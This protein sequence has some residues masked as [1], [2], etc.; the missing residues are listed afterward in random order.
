M[1]KVIIKRGGLV[2]RNET[3]EGKSIEVQLSEKMAGEEIELGGKALL[4]TERKDG[5]LP[6]TNI[7]SDRWDLAMM[8]LDSVERARISK[9]DSMGSKKIDE[10]TKVIEPLP[11]TENN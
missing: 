11:G 3:Y 10:G 8:A 5:V 4:Y 6:E 1:R 9:R 2:K 7:R